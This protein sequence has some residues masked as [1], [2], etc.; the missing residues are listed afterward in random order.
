MEDLHV[1]INGRV[2]RLTSFH[3]AHYRQYLDVFGTLLGFF[4][5][6]EWDKDQRLSFEVQGKEKHSKVL[7]YNTTVNVK[8]IS[9]MG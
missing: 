9:V 6:V 7:T 3:S 8:A 1:G 2:N 4:D 5:D